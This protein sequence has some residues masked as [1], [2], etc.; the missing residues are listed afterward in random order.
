MKRCLILAAWLIFAALSGA[1]YAAA[2][3]TIFN[4]PTTDTVPTKSLYAEFDFLAQVPGDRYSRNYLLNPRLVVGARHDL[5]FG[6]NFPVSVMRADGDGSSDGYIQPNVKWKLYNNDNAGIAVAVGGILNTPLNHR[7]AQD[8][9]GIIYGL[10]SKRIRAGDYG[11]RIHAGAYGIVSANQ[12]PANGAVSFSGPRAG[13]ILGYEQPIRRKISLV[14]DWYSGR[15]SIGYF[16][17]GVSFTL[18]GRGL[19]NAGYSFG[20][21]TWADA[22][23]VK[24]RYFFVYYG[25]SF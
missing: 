25:V 15:N 18:P 17:P 24:N 7:D 21:D 16:T 22:N 13:A 23:A 10:F 11:P 19:L 20:N 3:S 14:A 2:Q 12:N 8:S 6:V 1:D 9:W 5:E 4:V